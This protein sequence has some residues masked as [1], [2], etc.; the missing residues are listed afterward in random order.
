MA[1]PGKSHY[2]AG[3]IRVESVAA[4]KTI[5]AN[6]TGELYLCADVKGNTVTLP[7]VAQGAYCK[8]VFTDELRI[9]AVSNTWFTLQTAAAT[10][11]LKGM[12]VLISGSHAM[13]ADQPHSTA[14]KNTANDYKFIIAGN[15]NHDLYR[16]S[17]IECESDGDHW[18][19]SST[20]AVTNMMLSGTFHQ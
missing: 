19:L 10:Q 13:D 3:K 6:E 18:Y 2:N 7:Q 1:T 20:L 5:A 16:G 8:F 9:T 12:S 11:H 17:W 15:G 14:F 4:D